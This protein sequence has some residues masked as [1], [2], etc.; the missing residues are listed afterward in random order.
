MII[1]KN[2]SMSKLSPVGR[3]SIY[4]FGQMEIGD[5]FKVPSDKLIS[6]RNA[7]SIYG[8]RNGKKYTV[9]KMEDGTHRCWRTA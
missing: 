5:S 2:V 6:V 1:E 3:K 7:S 9:R 4:P 8:T